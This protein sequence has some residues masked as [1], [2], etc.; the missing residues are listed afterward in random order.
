MDLTAAGPVSSAVRALCDGFNGF[1]LDLHRKL[2]AG[3]NTFI[4]P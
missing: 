2:P 1:G 4:S 3:G